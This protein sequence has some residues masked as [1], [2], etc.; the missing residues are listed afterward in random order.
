[1][2]ESLPPAPVRCSGIATDPTIC[3]GAP[4]LSGSGAACPT[5]GVARGSD[6]AV[7][8]VRGTRGVGRGRTARGRRGRHLGRFAP[9]PPRAAGADGADLRAGRAAVL[10]LVPPR[11]QRGGPRVDPEPAADREAAGGRGLHRARPR[12]RRLEGHGHAQRGVPGEGR[13][14]THRGLRGR[15]DRQLATGGTPFGY[16]PVPIVV[17][18]DAHG[19]PRTQGAGWRRI[20]RSRRPW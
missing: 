4:Q 13:L 20:P 15:F 3:D 12:E 1:M 10:R 14:D 17:G 2:P 9:Q 19:H 16:R 11:P 8:R 7:P 5:C 18:K 6:R